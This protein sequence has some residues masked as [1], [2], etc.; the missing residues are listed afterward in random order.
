MARL[1]SRRAL[2]SELLRVN[3]IGGCL[4]LISACGRSPGASD[5]IDERSLNASQRGLRAS[6]HYMP[7]SS[8]ESR[9]CAGCAFFTAADESRCGQCRILG[10]AVSA[11][12]LCD[13]WAKAA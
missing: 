10:A 3:G 4:L 9:Q 11:Q 13:S 5:C 8:A 2:L 1:F 6:L 12:G 7:R